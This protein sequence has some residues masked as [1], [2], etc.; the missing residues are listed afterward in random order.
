MVYDLH[1]HTS[2]YS[3][4]AVSSAEQM[5]LTAVAVGL[6]GIALT[7]HDVW[8]PPADLEKLQRR[9]PE[10]AIIRGIECSSPEGHFLVFL[11][12]PEK[13]KLPIWSSVVNLI[14]YVQDH[15]G[16]VIWAHPF[17]FNASWPQWLDRVQPDG[18]EIS[19]SNMHRQAE[20]MAK[21]LAAERGILTFRNSDAHIANIL[22]RYG[23][24]L[25]SPLTGAEDLISHIHQHAAERASTFIAGAGAVF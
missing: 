3:A 11:P 19:S 20:A 17:R 6:A 25:D 24:K 22:G 10:L 14:P 15:G 4:C 5:C 23:N 2:E 21:K 1:V 8:W 9:F 12:Y 13:V 18:M 7:D 16:I